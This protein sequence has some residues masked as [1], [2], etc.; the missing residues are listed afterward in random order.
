MSGVRDSLGKL[1]LVL[2]GGIGFVLLD[3]SPSAL[4][5]MLVLGQMGRVGYLALIGGQS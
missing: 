2:L 5:V 4:L 1:G 3:V